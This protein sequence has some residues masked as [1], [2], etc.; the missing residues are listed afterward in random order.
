MASDCH[1][2]MYL[3]LFWKNNIK[4]YSFRSCQTENIQNK[5]IITRSFSFGFM[6]FL[7]GVARS[8]GLREVF[9]TLVPRSGSG[10]PTTTPGFSSQNFIH[11][12][13]SLTMIRSGSCF[14][15]HSYSSG[16]DRNA[17]LLPTYSCC[18]QSVQ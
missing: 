10:E 3:N 7:G 14:R 9:R 6:H 8:L 2:Q 1:F 13:F 18:L 5:H 16:S 4:S 11:D 12:R 15:G 17:L